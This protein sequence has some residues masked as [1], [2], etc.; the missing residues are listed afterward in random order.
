MHFISEF[1]LSCL[2]WLQI[3]FGRVYWYSSTCSYRVSNKLMLI[4]LVI[5]PQICV[6]PNQ[7]LNQIILITKNIKS[8]TEKVIKQ[9]SDNHQ[10][11]IRQSSDTHQTVIRQSSDTHQTLIRQS[12]DSHQ[13]V[14]RWSL[15]VQ[16]M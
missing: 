8:C 12:S 15:T 5:V 6:Y 4:Q 16:L 7:V 3:K 13:T 1:P 2:S 10:T 11:V 14:I 9:Q